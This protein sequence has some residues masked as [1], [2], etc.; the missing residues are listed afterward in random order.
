MRHPVT[1]GVRRGQPLH[2]RP[3]HAVRF[4][5]QHQVPVV[6]HQTVRQQPYITGAPLDRFFQHTLE[7]LEVAVLVEHPP[8]TRRPV[9]DVVR[10]AADIDAGWS[11]HSK[12]LF[13]ATYSVKT[14]SDPV[15][16]LGGFLQSRADPVSFPL[17]FLSQKIRLHTFTNTYATLFRLINSPY[18][19]PT[20]WTVLGSNS[21]KIVTAI[22]TDMAAFCQ[23][24]NL[25]VILQSKK[26]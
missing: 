2:D 18:F 21:L 24:A 26:C 17:P 1:P 7:R 6:A 20:F 12:S 10:V 19:S 11:G 3:E 9:Q 22:Y 25:L 14:G 8:V 13:A 5:L 4:R 16:Y 23:P 15:S